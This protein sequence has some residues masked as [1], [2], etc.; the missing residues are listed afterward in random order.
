M[1]GSLKLP[2]V[3]LYWDKAIGITAFSSMMTRDRFFQLRSNLHLVDVN[4][5]KS[6]SD[7][8]YK[9]WPM[10]DSI[11]QRCL[12]LNVEKIC[13]IDEQIVP[14][15]GN[16]NI[17]Q[18]VKNKPNPWGVK[19][20]VLCGISGLAYDFLV[21]QGSTTEINKKIRFMVYVLLS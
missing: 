2:R 3:N 19:I 11:R 18:Y 21:Y 6:D 4:E 10:Y 14:F 15:R 9:V 16:L 12:Q 13:S 20:F 1:M 5:C 17:K 8:I 7:R